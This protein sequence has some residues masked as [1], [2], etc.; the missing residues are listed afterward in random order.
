[1]IELMGQINITL[2]YTIVLNATVGKICAASRGIRTPSLVLLARDPRSPT[3]MSGS[4]GTLHI[5]CFGDSAHS[6]VG[7]GFCSNQ[8]P[9]ESCESH[10]FELISSH[11]IASPHLIASF[12]FGQSI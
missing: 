9:C 8:G 12:R 10:S 2:P 7:G 3:L 4:C 11:L 5:A 6:L 1:M